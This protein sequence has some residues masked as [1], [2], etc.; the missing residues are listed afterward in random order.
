M[1]IRLGAALASAITITFGWI[2]L[3]GLLLGDDLGLP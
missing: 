2:T 1:R 3:L